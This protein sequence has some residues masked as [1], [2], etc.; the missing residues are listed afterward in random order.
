MAIP[1]S[2]CSHIKK[3]LDWGVDQINGNFF[4]A[5]WGCTKCDW[6]SITLEEPI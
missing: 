6:C 1:D 4:I 3:V 5:L 2:E